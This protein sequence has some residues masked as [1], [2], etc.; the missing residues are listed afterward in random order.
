MKCI[1]YENQN[2]YIMKLSLYYSRLP[3]LTSEKKAYFLSI[4]HRDIPKRAGQG[5]AES[6]PASDPSHL[7]EAK[8]QA[9]GQVY[10][11]RGSWAHI[12]TYPT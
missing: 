9:Q 4:F 10:D 6:R 3:N 5:E 7:Q 2:E 11:C 1:F 12:H 8:N